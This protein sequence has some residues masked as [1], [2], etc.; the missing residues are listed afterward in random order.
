MKDIK[1]LL[2]ELMRVHEEQPMEFFNRL[3]FE[4]EMLAE[5]LHIKRLPWDQFFMLH[6]HLAATRSTCDRG[7]ELLFDQGRHGVGCVIVKDK[8]IIAGGYNGSPPGMPHCDDKEWTGRELIHNTD[9]KNG[10]HLM[11][12]GHCV[13]TIH[14]EMNAILQCALHGVS[15]EGSDVYTT[16]SPCYDCGKVLCGA[17][18]KRVLFGESYESRY[19]LSKDV[20][21]LFQAAGIEYKRVEVIF[22]KGRV[23]KRGS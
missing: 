20:E 21:A 22:V 6:A 13:R 8:R 17:K 18:V 5:P 14:S 11:K 12:D 1:Q 2:I 15:P 4:M 9:L 23:M 16:A 7:P 10:G 3:R 19:G